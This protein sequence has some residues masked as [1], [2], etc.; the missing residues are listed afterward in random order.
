M[1]PGMVSL[2]KLAAGRTSMI[3]TVPVPT[4]PLEFVSRRRFRANGPIRFRINLV[5]SLL[6][7][8]GPFG[9]E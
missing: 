8:K 7:C 2:S 1:A 6:L 9:K 5:F 3:F 4:L